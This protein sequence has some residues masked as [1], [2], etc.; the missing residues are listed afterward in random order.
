MAGRPKTRERREREARKRRFDHA[1]RAA[2]VEHADKVGPTQAAREAGIAVATIRTWRKRTAEEPKRPAPPQ[3]S[4]RGTRAERLRAAA[5]QARAASSRALDQSDAMLRRGLASEARNAATVAGINADRAQELE[6]SAR[7]EEL[8]EVSVTEQQGKSILALIEAML[9]DLGI[10][11]PRA[12]LAARLMGTPD[13]ELIERAREEV[14]GPIARELREEV[15]AELR[16]EGWRAPEEDDEEQ[17]PDAAAEPEE[18]EE[19]A[20]EEADPYEGRR[21][22]PLWSEVGPEGKHHWG[23]NRTAARTELY[24]E[25]VA[26]RQRQGMGSDVRRSNRFSR[27]FRGPGP[28]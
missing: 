8:H 23:A 9:S 26:K 17:A 2:I 20:A 25:R 6:A 24:N 3:T 10:E 4:E 7:E 18:P 12:L 28:L 14:R 13:A 5:D 21:D 27:E 1:Q 19:P 15:L 11:P 16:A 22:L